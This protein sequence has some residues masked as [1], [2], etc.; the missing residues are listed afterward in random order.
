[1][2]KLKRIVTLALTSAM[3][4]G[5]VSCGGSAGQTSDTTAASAETSE[6]VTTQL[7]DNLPDKDMNGFSLNILHHSNSWLTWARIAL[8]TD[9]E[10][11]D[12]IND[13]IFKRN[14]AIEERFNC[15]LHVEEVDKTESVFKSLV[16]SGD[17]TYDL[18]FQYGL[19]VLN[20]VDYM[21]D[22]SK[23]P[24]IQ[25]DKDYWNPMVTDVFR[26]GDKLLA[27]A[28]NFT[29][30]YLSGASAF[31]F[32]KTIFNDLNTGMNLYQ[33][34]DDGKWTT[35]KFYEVAK[36]GVKDLNGDTVIDGKD[37]IGLIGQA[38]SYYNSLILGAGF[39][40]VEA[41]KDNIPGFN[42]KNNEKM[43]SFLQKIVSTESANPNIYLV[44][45]EMLSRSDIQNASPADSGMDFKSGQSLFDQDMI[46]AIETGMRDMKDDFG[47]LPVP[48]YD[49]NQDYHYSY[50]SLGEIMTLPRSFDMARAENVGLLLEAMSFY[51]QQNIVPLYKETVL[52]VKLT[53]DEDSAR[54]L[55]HIFGHIVFD[56]ATSVWQQEI[57]TEL[58]KKYLLPRSDTL[59]STVDA[60]GTKLSVSI[61]KLVQSA[62]NVP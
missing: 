36:L 60:I 5:T 19:Y 48:K 10:N 20:N 23:I 42:L 12:L 34:V 4:L 18:I 45:K 31:L 61:D 17:N 9:E 30:S 27:A 13:A 1:M 46:Y 26:V 29:L 49:E 6:A 14:L 59:V 28:G 22:F 50:A 15:Q 37:R 56:H 32:N 38:K 11:G 41:D 24:Y 25:L 52:Q 35:D 16:M 62:A 3:T 53:R 8:D 7:S 51:S 43:I 21:S 55:D 2:N 40:Y 58:I 57:T 54:M 47:I 33:L 39:H 44:T